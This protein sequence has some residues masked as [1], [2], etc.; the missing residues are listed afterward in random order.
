[1][2]EGRARG[3]GNSLYSTYG[4]M[5]TEIFA[6]LYEF[7]YNFASTKERPY[8]SDTAFD[9]DKDGNDV[10]GGNFDNRGDVT[11]LLKRMKEQFAPGVA[12][13]LV[14]SLGRR[15]DLDPRIVPLAKERFHDAVRNV[16]VA[17]P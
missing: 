10:T 3:S 8:P 7:P 13:G 2:Q 1:M 17:P 4:Y 11:R 9:T 12:Q 5:E 15:I 14:A 6:E 16:F